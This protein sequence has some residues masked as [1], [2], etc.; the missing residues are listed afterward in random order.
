MSSKGITAAMSGMRTVEDVTGNVGINLSNANTP[1]FK[2]FDAF[3][4]STT[5]KYNGGVTSK[6]AINTDKQGE[7]LKTEKEFDYAIEGRGFFPVECNGEKRFTAAGGF[8]PDND[9]YLRGVNGCYLL[10]GN[11][12]SGETIRKTSI[13]KDSANFGKV[14]IPVGDLIKGTATSTVDAK[15]VLSAEQLAVGGGTIKI[16]AP[17]G[18]GNSFTM[19]FYQKKGDNDV[20]SKI[21]T[22][23]MDGAATSAIIPG[24]IQ[25]TNQADFETKLESNAGIYF[26]SVT[27]GSGAKEFALHG[28]LNNNVRLKFDITSAGGAMMP[29]IEEYANGAFGTPFTPTLGSFISSP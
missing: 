19:T 6:S 26:D 16:T 24:A 20:T 28:S 12:I 1:G 27:G 7:I 11:Y 25:Y 9:G 3:L 14:K 5:N 23:Q 15:V 17:T 10:A 2:E 4:I 18:A 13:E 21:L 8:N 22:F 29:S